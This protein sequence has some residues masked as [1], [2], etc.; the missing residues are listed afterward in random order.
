MRHLAQGG[1]CSLTVSFV[2]PESQF[3][4][5]LEAAER[6]SNNRPEFRVP[7]ASGM[8]AA[9]WHLNG[10]WMIGRSLAF[11]AVPSSTASLILV[12]IG[13]L[14]APANRCPASAVWCHCH[15]GSRQRTCGK[16]CAIRFAHL[17]EPTGSLAA[18]SN[19]KAWSLREACAG[20]RHQ[21]RKDKP[22]QPPLVRTQGSLLVKRSV[23]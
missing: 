13:E 7:E 23:G 15:R 17:D 1:I 4:I 6:Y 20:S 18:V 3:S 12:T 21:S 16:F 10:T 19:R 2:L 22:V 14:I 11:L 9:G 8:V 5:V